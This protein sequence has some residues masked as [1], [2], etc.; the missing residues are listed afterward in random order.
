MKTCV[1][2]G[3]AG[4]LGSHLCDLLLDKNYQVL[5]VDNLITGSKKNIEHLLDKKDFKFLEADVTQDSVYRDYFEEKV[6]FVFHLASPASPNKESKMSYLAH[7][8]ETLLVNS[9]GTHKLLEL[10]KKHNARFLFA[11]TSEV[12]GDPKEHPQKESY[13]G[14]V[15]PNGLRSCYDEGKRFG[16][17]ITKV[18]ERENGLDIRI[19][20]IFNTY[21]PRM[22]DDG[23]VVVNFILQGL[24]KEPF[25]IYGNGEQTRSFC[26]VSDLVE[27]IFKM[28][29]VDKAKGKIINL[30]NPEEYSVKALAE[31][32][33][34]KVKVE[35]DIEKREKPE[36][37]PEKRRPDISR[38]RE[39][40]GWSPR[41]SLDEGLE[42]T[43]EYF[44]ALPD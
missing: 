3:G 14:N 6:D 24:K 35:M 1:V 10:C 18:Y 22:A 21:G 12:Y 38:A 44:A 7:P 43:I 15:N 41:V 2:T 40:L 28:M 16:E 5:C 25:T 27:G 32:V 29:F 9:V 37:D 11:S 36:D 13:F 39:I 34:E 4:F 26:Y 31:K 19:V 23:R 20:R 42:K 8:L 33:A 17:S 30:G